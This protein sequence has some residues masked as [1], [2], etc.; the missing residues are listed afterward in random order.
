[1]GQRVQGIDWDAGNREKCEKHGVSREEVEEL[2][3]HDL[4]VAPDPAH[5]GAEQRYIAVGRNAAGRPMLVAFT[6]REKAGR[7]LIRP[8]SARYMHPKE[9]ERYEQEGTR[10]DDG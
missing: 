3:L 7:L 6:F 5:S 10:D 1:M 8:V 9:A 4:G 2:L